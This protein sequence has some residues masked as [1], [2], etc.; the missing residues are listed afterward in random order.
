MLTKIFSPT[1]ICCGIFAFLS[2]ET[3]SCANEIAS[4]RVI[5]GTAAEFIFVESGSVVTAVP[6]TLKIN[7][8]TQPGASL[9]LQ[10]ATSLGNDDA[11]TLS[12]NFSYGLVTDKKEFDTAASR[13]DLK[14]KSLSLVQSMRFITYIV[15][16]DAKTGRFLQ[17]IVDQGNL[18]TAGTLVVSHQID[19]ADKEGVRLFFQQPKPFY[20]LIDLQPELL[21]QVPRPQTS[22]VSSL[23]AYFGSFLAPST[24]P[25]TKAISDLYSQIG[26]ALVYDD[27][28]LTSIARE[29][30]GYK[31]V[32]DE[33]GEPALVK[34]DP[35]PGGTPRATGPGGGVRNVRVIDRVVV[36][37]AIEVCSPPNNLLIID[38]GKT[39]CG[40]I[41]EL[42]SQ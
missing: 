27:A 15:A 40:S 6:R 9:I 1:V 21:I 18:N 25:T 22:F 16:Y 37:N 36:A 28:G 3:I 39:G 12:I 32:V 30:Q 2:Q 24:A 8:S 34:P 17:K 23:V 20:V 13:L 14:N 41:K 4:A 42:L 38:I 29:I 7:S 11:Y 19:F 26:S 31:A 5:T 10:R 35:P 33:K